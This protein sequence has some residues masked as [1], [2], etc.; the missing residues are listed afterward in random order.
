MNACAWM[1]RFEWACVCTEIWGVDDI[2]QQSKIVLHN[3]TG[4]IRIL[5]CLCGLRIE[6]LE[7]FYVADVSAPTIIQKDY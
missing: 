2:Y 3:N 6:A 5:I 1:Q 7:I 4:N